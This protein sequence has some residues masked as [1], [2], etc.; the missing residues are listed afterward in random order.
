MLAHAE[1]VAGE[2]VDPSWQLDGLSLLPLLKDPQAKLDPRTLYWRRKGVEGPIA[3]REQN[4]KL[5]LHYPRRTN[6]ALFNL[7]EDIGE[8]RNIAAEHPDIVARLTAKIESWES[9]LATPLWGP[10]SSGFTPKMNGNNR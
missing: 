4:W 8:T 9:E 2:P 5:Y 1:I 7:S 10:G 6:P 3:L